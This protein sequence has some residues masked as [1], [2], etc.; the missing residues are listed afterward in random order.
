MSV[1]YFVWFSFSKY[2]FCVLPR[3]II[4]FLN[5]MQLI[6]HLIWNMGPEKV[7]DKKLWFGKLRWNLERN[8]IKLKCFKLSEWMLP[9][10]KFFFLSLIKWIQFSYYFQTHIFALT[11]I[12]LH[13][14]PIHFWLIFFLY[15]YKIL[16]KC[17]SG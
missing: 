10:F 7:A 13:T 17:R 1:N 11:Q 15:I 12:C 2:K 16:K 8:V 6:E 5:L 9:F 4:G 14:C 3:Y